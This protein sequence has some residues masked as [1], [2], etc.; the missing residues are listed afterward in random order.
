MWVGRPD[1]PP[2]GGVLEEIC[3]HAADEGVDELQ[4]LAWEWGDLDLGR[5]RARMVERFGVRLLPRTIPSE[6]IEP[7]IRKL[8]DLIHEGS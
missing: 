6:A 3:A 1:A 2:T 4:V 8:A 7:G 5:L